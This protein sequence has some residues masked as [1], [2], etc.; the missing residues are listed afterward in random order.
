MGAYSPDYNSESPY[1]FTSITGKFMT[2]YIHRTVAPHPFD[3]VTILN[4]ERYVNRPDILA[5]D[6]YG[7]EDL[8][9]IIPVRNGLQDP[10]FDLTF[11]RALIIPDTTYV[12]TLI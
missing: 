6:L 7:S 11:G 5:M 2:Y 12:R 3:K 9:W 1:N 8:F 10:V 4:N